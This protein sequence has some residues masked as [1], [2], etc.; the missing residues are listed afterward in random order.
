MNVEGLVFISKYSIKASDLYFTP[1]TITWCQLPYPGHKHGCPNY[2]K[3]KFCPPHSP[4]FFNKINHYHQLFLVIAHFDFKEYKKRMNLI[5]PEWSDRQ[6]RNVLYWQSQVKKRLKMYINPLNPDLILGCG[7]GLGTY[8]MESVQ[9]DV[10]KTLK[11]LQ[12]DIDV[13][14][15]DSV[16]LVCLIGYKSQNLNSFF[17]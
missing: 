5:H 14:P 7:S 2:N 10:I 8:S 3:S 15:I 6:L 17:H 16:K 1:K 12:I 11:N 9:I 13:K 4:N